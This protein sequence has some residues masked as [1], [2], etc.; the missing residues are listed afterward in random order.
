MVD[1]APRPASAT[2]GGPHL[3][4]ATRVCG[5][6]VGG[7][8]IA[9]AEERVG[10]RFSSLDEMIQAALFSESVSRRACA[11]SALKA[12]GSRVAREKLEIV[13]QLD[14]SVLVRRE[15]A[16]LV[17]QMGRTGPLQKLRS[18]VRNVAEH[19][20]VRLAAAEALGAIG[21]ARVLPFL[22]ECACALERETTPEVRRGCRL[23]VARLEWLAQGGD[24]SAPSSAYEGVDDVEQAR[25][26]DVN[27]LGAIVRNSAGDSYER[28]S[29]IFALREMGSAEAVAQLCEALKG[30]EGDFAP[31]RYELAF[32]LGQM[33]SANAVEALVGAL[34]DK[35]E[36][37]EVRYEAA[38][39]LGAIGVRSNGDLLRLLHIHAGRAVR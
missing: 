12:E 19:P 24:P 28:Y 2:G 1:P 5:S 8:M 9:R 27:A 11:I 32:V 4:A 26:L 31:F 38:E 6:V 10:E 15:A 7:S 3:Y 13:M 21:D 20:K 23:A 34:M 30:S 17:G 16:Y 29:A 14:S 33:A 35:N 39:A 25:P 37:E 36:K 18:T 22:R